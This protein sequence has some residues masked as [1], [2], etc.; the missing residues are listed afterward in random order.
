MNH[1]ILRLLTLAAA[2]GAVTP[3]LRAQS[4]P[5]QSQ[6]VRGEI[7]SP[8]VG[9]LRTVAFEQNLDAQ[10]PLDAKFR[11]ESGK[12][13]KLG[14]YFG[15]KPVIVTF[16]YYECP[17]LCKL[18]LTGL[19]SNLKVLSMSAGKE[20]DIVTVSIDP[21]ETPKLASA[22]KKGY[23]ER[24]KRAGAE[25]GWHF[26]T[27]AEPEIKRLTNAAGF[28]YAFDPKSKQYAHPAGLVIATPGGKIA[29]YVYGVDFPANNLRW[30]L[31]D[32]SSGKIGTPV[33]RVLLMCFHY[34]PSTGRYNFA[35]MSAVRFFGVA[36]LACLATFV[37]V[38]ARRDRLKARTADAF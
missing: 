28:K 19:V 23:M 15:K 17:M 7:K 4:G 32:A 16:V 34:D 36:T 12:E 10:L 29:R 38:S 3:G 14:D 25:A 2:L 11:D 8:E 22:H 21:T 18:E 5:G 24:Y 37:L 27:G 6:Q 13:V 20:F 26:L 1:K 35:V 33:D 30:S 9:L 31:I